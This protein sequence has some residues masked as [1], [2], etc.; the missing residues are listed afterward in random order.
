M[1]DNLS[2]ARSN[3]FSFFLHRNIPPFHYQ[4]GTFSINHLMTFTGSFIRLTAN[5]AIPVQHMQQGHKQL[6]NVLVQE[7]KI[8]SQTPKPWKLSKIRTPSKSHNLEVLRGTSLSLQRDLLHT[9][10]VAFPSKSKR[11]KGDRTCSPIHQQTSLNLNKLRSHYE[12]LWH[13]YFNSIQGYAIFC[14]HYY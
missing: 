6:S 8:V 7:C 5:L 10:T 3:I 4:Q 11:K 9:S 1:I 12:T 13:Y 2:F 14:I